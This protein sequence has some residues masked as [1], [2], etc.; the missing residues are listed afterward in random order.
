M[1]L[2]KLFGRGE[3]PSDSVPAPGTQFG[4]S[5]VADEDDELAA[6][7]ARRRE[8]VLRVLS[9]TLRKHGIPSDW[10]TCRIV[11]VVTST[12]RSG[13]HVQ[14]VVRGGGD[15]LLNYVRAFQKS[16]RSEL[17]KHDVRYAEWLLSL[18]WQ[19]DDEPAHGHAVMPDRAAWTRSA[20]TDPSAASAP[21]PVTRPA[22][23]QPEAA[24]DEDLDDH[25]AVME[26]IRALMAIR[27]AVPAPEQQPPD[28]PPDFEDTQ[29]GKLPPEPRR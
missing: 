1:S 19:F 4:D 8:L 5:N 23:A 17:E 14:L 2:R 26:D 7:N 6:R 22:E 13:M 24:H 16:L 25:E 20:A 18:A 15:D 12:N 27:D 3:S 9:E 21:A 11:P 28:Q 10:I 29:P